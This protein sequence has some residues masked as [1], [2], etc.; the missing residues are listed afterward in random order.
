[1]CWL[2]DRLVDDQPFLGLCDA[3]LSLQQTC[4]ALDKPGDVMIT[5]GVASQDM[6][7]LAH[8][9]MGY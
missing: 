9:N 7:P 1:M 6:G 2:S 3:G 4:A 8:R 5:L